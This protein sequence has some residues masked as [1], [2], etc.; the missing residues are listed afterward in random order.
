MR[1]ALQHAR[2]EESLDGVAISGS[3]CAQ[4]RLHVAV[5]LA[6]P[7]RTAGAYAWEHCERACFLTA[8]AVRAKPRAAGNKLKARALRAR[9]REIPLRA[10]LNLATRHHLPGLHSLR[11]QPFVRRR[12]ACVAVGDTVSPRNYLLPVWWKYLGS[13]GGRLRG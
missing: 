1:N 12:W 7:W 8:P 9:A 6:F 4:G 10:P 2:A 3:A 5:F 13:S 11:A